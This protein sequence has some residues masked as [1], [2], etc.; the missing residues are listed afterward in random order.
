MQISQCLSR[1]PSIFHVINA[2]RLPQFTGNRQR[3]ADYDQISSLQMIARMGSQAENC[4]ANANQPR[5]LVSRQPVCHQWR[6]NNTIDCGTKELLGMIDVAE[7]C[8]LTVMMD[9]DDATS[10]SLALLCQPPATRLNQPRGDT[11]PAKLLHVAE[12]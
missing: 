11:Y 4:D 9:D 7:A 10:E 6:C 5:P 2:S 3:V 1:Y 12:L 8:Q